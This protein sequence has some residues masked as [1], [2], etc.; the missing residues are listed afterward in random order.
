LDLVVV[1]DQGAFAGRAGVPGVP[2][3]GREGQEPC[4]DACF[5]AFKGA[6]AVFFEGE[7]AFEG[8]KD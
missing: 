5:D 8:V 6:P 7:L 3:A 1:G 4:S 2:D